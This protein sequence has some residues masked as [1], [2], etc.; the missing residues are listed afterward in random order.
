[1]E[2]P[3]I[4]ELE[5]AYSEKVVFIRLNEAKNPEAMDEFAVKGFPTMFLVYDKSSSNY[6]YYDF[7]G[8]KDKAFLESIIVQMIEG[9]LLVQD[10]SGD[11]Q[12]LTS[13]GGLFSHESCDFGDCVDACTDKKEVDLDDLVRELAE[14]ITGCVDPSIVTDIYGCGKALLT[15]EPDDW[16]GCASS[17]LGVSKAASCSYSISHAL[18][19]LLG[20]QQ[21]G[22]CLGECAADPS[23]HGQL[24]QPGEQRSTCINK[25]FYKMEECSSDCEWG[26]VPGSV[27]PC[28]VGTECGMTAAGAEC[29][30]IDICEIEPSLPQCNDPDNP[31][32]PNNPNNPPITPPSHPGN[33]KPDDNYDVSTLTYQNSTYSPLKT[34]SSQIVA[35]LNR[36][37]YS[38]IASLLEEL[39]QSYTLVTLSSIPHLDPKRYPVLIVASGGL[40][41]LASLS[42]VRQNLETYVGKGGKLIVFSQQRGVDY[43]VLPGG[44]VGGFGWIEDQSCWGFS[45]IISTYHPIVSGQKLEASG[46]IS[47][48][49]DGFFTSFPSNAITILTRAKTGTPSMI[50]YEYGKGH[51]LASTLY[52]D[53]QWSNVWHSPEEAALLRDMVVWA[54]SKNKIETYTFSY[55]NEQQVKIPFH[56]PVVFSPSWPKFRR[57]D[58]VTI[59]IN[60][61][62]YGNTTANKVVFTLID[63][64]YNYWYVNVSVSIPPNEWRTVNLNYSTTSASNPG[65]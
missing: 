33:D 21:L 41:G 13:M 53:V 1:L 48:H 35:V 14:A 8:F 2:K 55:T 24:C 44:E 52:S 32:N 42:S 46:F 20:A 25:Y 23:S 65:I 16:I 43:G 26:Y 54:L 10:Q 17:L 45:S 11:S 56:N 57:G 49:V 62:N 47:I 51:V 29:R 61:T 15:N 12:C 60:V 38:G 63:P 4:E 37:Y 59:P 27:R 9:N 50:L 64:Y 22:E 3:I 39:N 40:Y 36:G 34:N 6:V 30:E 58:V 18:A 28:P 7:G 31:S 19:D 5:N